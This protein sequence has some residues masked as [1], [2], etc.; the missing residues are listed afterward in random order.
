MRPIDIAKKLNISTSS[1]RSYEERGLVPKPSR[2]SAGYRIYT[3][4][5]LLYFECII[6]MSPGFGI[7]HTA[8]VL[9]TLQREELDAALW[10]INSAQK[11]ANED[12]TL[13]ERVKE[14]LEHLDSEKHLPIKDVSLNTRTPAST[15]RYWEKE[16]YIQSKRGPNHYRCFNSYQVIKVMLMKVAQSAVYSNRAVQLKDNIRNLEDY[17]IEGAKDIIEECK[18][19]LNTRNQEQLSGLYHFYRLC[20]KL[21]LV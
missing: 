18:V 13:I 3:E 4:E 14:Y 12:R 10:I 2:S 17:N 7:N 15:L 6:A 8:A 11:A 20:S 19:L 16:G 5:H 9:K 21:R 1:L